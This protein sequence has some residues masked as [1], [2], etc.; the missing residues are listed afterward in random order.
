MDEEEKKIKDQEEETVDADTDTAEDGVSDEAPVEDKTLDDAPSVD[1]GSGED[2]PSESVLDGTT[3]VEDTEAVEEQE[4]E[5]VEKMLTQSQ[6][7]ELVGKARAEG[8][9]AGRSEALS[10]LYERYGVDN[11]DEMNGVFGK[12]QGYDLLNDDYTALNDNYRNLSA[13]NALLK[14]GVVANRWGDVKAILTSKGLEINE[15][16]IRAESATHPEW[17]GSFGG[18]GEMNNASVREFTPELGE[19]MANSIKPRPQVKQQPGVIKK[20][21]SNI[22]NTD[23]VSEEAEAMR[24]FG[25]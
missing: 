21:G 13:E 2:V 11:D 1:N 15:E 5:P 16:N 17:I 10:E 6:V 8:R 4:A 22:P 14:S 24:L 23:D 25:L 9:A 19:E 20:L 18:D 3:P 7:N 12:G